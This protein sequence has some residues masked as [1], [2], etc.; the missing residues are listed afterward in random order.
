M[1]GEIRYIQRQ[2]HIHMVQQLKNT[3]CYNATRI[4]QCPD[5]TTV[6]QEIYLIYTFNLFLLMQL[7]VGPTPKL[8]F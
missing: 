6:S 8:I 5:H 2:M 1:R 4:E 7:I 3:Q